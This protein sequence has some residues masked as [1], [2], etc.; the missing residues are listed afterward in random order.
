M[1]SLLSN[2]YLNPL[3]FPPKLCPLKFSFSSVVVNGERQA[4][5]FFGNVF[6]TDY[7]SWDRTEVV[8]RN[9]GCGCWSGVKGK[10]R[11]LSDIWSWWGVEVSNFNLSPRLPR[12]I[13]SAKE[14][15]MKSEKLTLLWW[16]VFRSFL[17]W[18]Q[19]GQLTSKRRLSWSGL[20]NHPFY[21]CLQIWK[22]PK[23]HERKTARSFNLHS[24]WAN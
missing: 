13:L 21:V 12:I 22:R 9:R 20:I 15:K 5:S 1:L 4:T 7:V 11:F 19:Y 16:T 17:R 8:R 2:I 24:R 14:N 10:I 3:S 18:S 6:R 23:H